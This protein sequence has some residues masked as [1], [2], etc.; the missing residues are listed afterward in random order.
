MAARLRIGSIV[1]ALFPEH[2]PGAHEQEGYRP[3][4]VVGWPALAG[5]PRFATLLV[6]PLTTDRGQDWAIASP[7][8]YPRLPAGI[9]GLRSPSICLL[10][11]VRALSMERVYRIRGELNDTQYGPVR[12]G[13]RLMFGE[14][15]KGSV[16]EA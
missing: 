14:A 3:A 9:A 7:R 10:D 8:L 13:L 1:A 2:R 16:G 11:Q 5:Q 4:V 12:E 6:A 15:G